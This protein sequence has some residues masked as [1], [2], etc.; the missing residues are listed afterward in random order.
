MACTFMLM[1]GCKSDKQNTN[2]TTTIPEEII[3]SPE[4]NNYLFAYFVGDGS[5]QE[6]IYFAVSEDGMNW[7]GLNNGEPVFV[8]TLGTTGLRDPFIIRS[9]E[10]DKYYLIA[11][12]LCIG[13]SK[14]WGKAQTEG[15]TSIMVWESADLI[16]WSEQRMAKINVDTAGCTWAPEAYY[17]KEIGEYMVFWASKTADDGYSKQRIYYVTTKDFTTFSE[18]KVWMDY[19]HSVIDATI[20]EEDGIYYRFVKNEETRQIFMESATSL[21]GEWTTMESKMLKSKHGVEGPAI[22]EFHEEDVVDGQKY[23]LLLDN[24]V[25]IGYYMLTTDSLASGEFIRNTNTTMPAKK[26]RHGTV[27]AITTEEYQALLDKYSN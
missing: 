1:A 10:G 20:I 24:Y 17:N 27:I 22:F 18:P 7:T 9:P 2:E 13:K 23:A 16:T 4:Y 21:L 19:P 3:T 5:G 12:D 6:S 14:D 26:P 15:S 25:G 8:S 11:T